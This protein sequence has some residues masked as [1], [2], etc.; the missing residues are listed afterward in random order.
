MSQD[1]TRMLGHKVRVRAC[2]LVVHEDALLLVHLQAPTRPDPFWS[3]PGGGVQHGE[4]LEEAVK[5]ELLEET[6]LEVSVTGLQYVAEFI[7]HPFHAVECYFLCQKTGGTLAKG[8]DPE[9]DARS[10]MILDVAFTPLDK[11]SDTLIF[12]EFIR[13]RFHEDVQRG[14][15]TPIWIH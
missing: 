13:H 14:I 7:Q 3:V 1:L 8:H 11:L 6:G 5:R 10:Q 4:S 12:P 2:G 15:N 9:F